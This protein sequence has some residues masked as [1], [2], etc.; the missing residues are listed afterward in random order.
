[1]IWKEALVVC[2]KVLFQHSTRETDRTEEKIQSGWPVTERDSIRVS[3]EYKP[4]ALSLN[5]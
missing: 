1:V 2:L 3:P 4:K 5:Y